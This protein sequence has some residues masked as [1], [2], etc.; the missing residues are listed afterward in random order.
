[1]SKGP[2]YTSGYRIELLKGD[3]WVPWKRRMLAVL[4]DTSLEKYIEKTAA[5]PIPADPRKPTKEETEAIDKW[6][7]GDAK[8]RTR[9]ELAIGDGEM[10]HIS[11]ALTD[12]RAICGINCRQ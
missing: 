1:M 9:I 8:A 12:S 7:G 10:I 11:G 5:P 3:N 6:N 2:S 4:R